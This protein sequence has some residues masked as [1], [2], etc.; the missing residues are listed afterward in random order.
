MHSPPDDL[1]QFHRF[2][3]P[4]EQTAFLVKSI[5]DDIRE[6]ELRAEDIVVINPNPLTTQREVGPARQ[7]LFQ[8]H[9]LI[10]S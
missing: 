4:A 5:I 3:N 9:R 1:I 8:N 2:D 10:A 6:E 7:L